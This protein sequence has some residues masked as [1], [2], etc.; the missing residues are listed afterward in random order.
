MAKQPNP[1]PPPLSAKPDPPPA[2]PR[3]VGYLKKDL[4]ERRTYKRIWWGPAYRV[5]DANGKDLFQPWPRTKG[6]AREACERLNIELIEG[7][8]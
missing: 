7:E 4:D 5:V 3:R 8:E 1:P 2:P 6:E